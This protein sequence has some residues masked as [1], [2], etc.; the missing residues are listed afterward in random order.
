[1]RPPAVPEELDHREHDREADARDRA[2]Y[3]HAGKA[4][5]G[6]PELPALDAV[7]A[8]QVG[9]LD[10]PDGRGDHDRGQR[11]VGRSCSRSG[12]TTSSAPTAS[13]P[14]TP[15]SWVRAPAASATGVRDALAL[16]GK[17]WKKPAARL[18][19]PSPTI[20]WLGS[21]ELPVRAA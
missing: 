6:Q 2:E 11:R 8:A 12:A 16:I 15:A 19:A 5:D 13:A 20:S 3:G 10:Q 18:A 1:M 21:T 7:D 4:A 14:T 17:P 9:D